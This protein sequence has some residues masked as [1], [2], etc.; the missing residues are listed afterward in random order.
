[1]ARLRAQPPAT[2]LGRPLD[3]LD[4]LAAGSGP[5]PRA[6]VLILR[7]PDVRVVVRP[8]GTEPKLKCYLEVVAGDLPEAASSWPRCAPS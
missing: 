4:D 7:A 8:S 3:A 6:E 2:L 1:M 5:P